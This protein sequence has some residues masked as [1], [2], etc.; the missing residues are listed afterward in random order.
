MDFLVK[1]HIPDIIG[2]FLLTLILIWGTKKMGKAS[3][4]I[5]FRLCKIETK[6]TKIDDLEEQVKKIRSEIKFLYEK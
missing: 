3:D 1:F 5:Y 4:Q 6:V 2:I